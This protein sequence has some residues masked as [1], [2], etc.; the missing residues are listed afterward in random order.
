MLFRSG[1]AYPQAAAVVRACCES[2]KEVGM[3]EA[4][5]PLSNAAVL[6]ATSPKSNSAYMAYHAALSDVE[7]GKGREIPT[8]L[9]S[10]LFKGYKY[11]HD[12]Q[13]H[14]VAQTYLPADLVGKTYYNYGENKTEQ[15][16]KAYNDMIKGKVK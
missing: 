11:P 5:I 8:H 3:P 7:A 4:A 14:Y 12:Y 15:A 6:L 13:N 2:A 10:P 9:K 16:A 1:A